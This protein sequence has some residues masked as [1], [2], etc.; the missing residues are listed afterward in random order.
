[1]VVYYMVEY[2]KSESLLLFLLEGIFL[3]FIAVCFSK[4]NGCRKKERP[5]VC[6]WLAFCFFSY[7]QMSCN[8]V[9]SEESKTENHFQVSNV[10]CKS[11]AFL[12]NNCIYPE[13]GLKFFVIMSQIRVTPVIYPQVN[14]LLCHCAIQNSTSEIHEHTLCFTLHA[15]PLT[16]NEL[17]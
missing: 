16:Y 5:T 15:F 12:C 4:S 7:Y 11:I 1:M 10:Y 2:T 9:D 8:T 6:S 13:I 14:M 17:W 3:L